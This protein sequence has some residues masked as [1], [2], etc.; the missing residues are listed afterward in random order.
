MAS[1][2]ITRSAA[3]PGVGGLGA[4]V[5]A[6]DAVAG[7]RVAVYYLDP[8]RGDPRVIFD[9]DRVCTIRIAP[10]VSSASAPSGFGPG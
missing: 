7:D 8:S 5:K 4:G 1:G 2:L 9:K 3:G 6:V 10:A